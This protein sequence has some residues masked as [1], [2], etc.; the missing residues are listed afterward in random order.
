MLTPIDTLTSAAGWTGPVGATFTV[1]QV[2]EFIANNLGASLVIYIPPN[3]LGQSFVKNVS[4][5]FPGASSIVLS[6]WSRQQ[7]RATQN[8]PADYAYEIDFGGGNV[9]ML[10]TPMTFDAVDIGINGWTDASQ[11]KI[12]PQTNNEDWLIISGC[13][14]VTDEYP[15]DV[16]SGIQDGIRQALATFTLPTIG[17]K[18]LAAGATSVAFSPWPSFLER[19]AVLKFTDG[20]HTEYH[21]IQR[22]DESAVQFTSLY[23]GQA[24][25]FSYAP[26]SISLWI[27]VEY[28]V[29]EKEA[30]VPAIT[31][32]GLNPVPDQSSSDVGTIVDTFTP[33]GGA[34]VRKNVMQQTYEVLIDCEARQVQTLALLSRAVRWWLGGQSVWINARRNDLRIDWQTASVEPTEATIQIPKIQFRIEVDAFEERQARTFLPAFT[35]PAATFTTKVGVLPNLHTGGIN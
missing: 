32:W 2:E 27:P 31:I 19:G 24:L 16:Y 20:T 4:A 10:P 25:K 14:A 6:V 26:A 35:T 1:N 34:A 7:R 28:G 18:T 30:V 22:W 21:Q 29:T 11:I 13:Y 33:S 23:D 8:K 15:L 5:S 17:S 12:I 3:S 9:F